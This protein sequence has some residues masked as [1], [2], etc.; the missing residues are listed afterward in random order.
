MTMSSVPATMLAPAPTLPATDADSLP[1]Q[2]DLLEPESAGGGDGLAMMLLMMER[3]A[4]HSMSDKQVRI[5][6]TRDNLKA[7]LSKFL[8]Q[9]E[10]AMRAIREAKEDDGGFFGNLLGS[11]AKIVGKIMG[12]LLEVS[13]EQMKLPADLVIGVG[14]SIAKDQSV[15]D[16]I[17]QTTFA[18]A[19]SGQISEDARGFTEGAMR[20][21]GDFMEFMVKA[22]AAIA[23]AALTG[24]DAGELL[25]DDLHQ[26]KSSVERN[27]VD[28][29]H[30]WA[31]TRAATA[32]AGA[33][34]ITFTAG[35]AT[36]LA[37]AGLSLLAVSE[38][39]RQTGFLNA[40]PGDLAPIARIGIQIGAA[41]CLGLGG[42]SASPKAL[43]ILEIVTK[44]VQG[45]ALVYDGAR[46]LLEGSREADDIDRAAEQLATL[47]SMQ[48]LQRMLE[49]LLDALEDDSE[50]HTRTRELGQA[51][52]STQTAT[53][54]A[55][56]IPA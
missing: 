28:N 26:L 45:A 55:V 24:E 6:E 48:R 14:T 50:D 41:V 9:I 46:T 40:L 38:A 31:V 19:E 20:F 35:A 15:L 8:D 37:V 53:E 30:F 22:N 29:P 16:S 4:Q 10:E 1:A 39:D 51:V 47:Q 5:Q 12:P 54:A 11:I 13:L 2:I 42:A 52:A 25:Q 7:E 18:L 43:E 34:A 17:K 21:T 49:Q 44:V 23:Q 36:P 27:I 33:I 32:A 56:I 3:A